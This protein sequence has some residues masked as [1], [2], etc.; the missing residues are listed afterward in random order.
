ME[1]S[2]IRCPHGRILLASNNPKKLRELVDIVSGFDMEVVTLRELGISLDVV[3]DGH[4]FEENASKKATAYARA[5]SLCTVADDSG[6]EVDALGGR[7]GVRSARYA[8]EKTD[9]AKNN[10]KLLDEM[11]DV[12]EGE[13]GAEF[14]CLIAFAHPERGV[15]FTSQG[16]V[17]GTILRKL[18]GQAGF[19][20]DPLFFYPP[21]GKT[22]AEMRPEEKNRVS[23]RYHALVQFRERL[24]AY[25]RR[26]GKEKD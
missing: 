25:F 7:P 14:R 9:F 12:P 2:E 19:G 26:G 23:H 21:A 10:A 5:S 1:T 13:R 17:R 6:L 22:F 24:D 15:L 8:S 11:R 20:Y 3:E 4:T 18:R 16:R